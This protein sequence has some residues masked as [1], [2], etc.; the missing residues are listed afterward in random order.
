MQEPDA[1]L[2]LEKNS[3]QRGY[4]MTMFGAYAASSDVQWSHVKRIRRSGM[5]RP[6]V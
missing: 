2:V 4:K 6:V 1:A 3:S 5:A